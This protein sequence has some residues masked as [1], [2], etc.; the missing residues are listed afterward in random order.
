MT[1][2]ATGNGA[3][4]LAGLLA[5]AFVALASFGNFYVYDSIGPVADLL[6]R[7][8]GYSDTQI[9]TLNAIYSIPN[10][11][12]LLL[13]GILVD[14]IGAGRALF[15]TAL[16]CFLGAALTAASPSFY[17][18]AAGRLL[19]GIGAETFN[20]ATLA[21]VTLFYPRRHT[22]LMM[23]ITIGVGRAGSWVADLSPSL[24][25]GVYDAG[26]QWP[27]V[28]SAAIAATS[29]VASAAY[30]AVEH[31]AARD[32]KGGAQAQPFAWRDV[33]RFDISYWYLLIL[34]V[35]WYGVILAFRST[36]AIK[37]FQHAH[38]L[39]LAEAGQINSH[40]FLAALFATPAFGWLCDR[41]GRYAG[42][43]AAGAAL[44]PV[45]LALMA[46]GSHGLGLATA[47]IGISYSL[48]PAAMWPLVSRLVEPNRFGTALGL[49]WVIQNA[50]IAGANLAA[51]WLNDRAGAS[52]LHP[53]GYQPM[54]VFFIAASTLG[55]GFAVLL[56]LRSR[57]REA[58]PAT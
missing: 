41:I 26:W 49:M 31:R 32:V 48:V 7:Q 43:L 12:L 16:T 18:M 17:V 3:S 29:L 42:L 24:W 36:F 58:A 38:R 39:T 44:L 37:Y 34:C 2:S 15:W 19:F 21:A 14:R 52:A 11:V 5:M 57:G 25:K 8:L 46:A 53:S 4:A 27:L 33:L 40:V 51:G 20:I 6:Q 1:E 47:F 10:V 50:G 45:S 35:L 23:G 13:G 28:L 22:A 30:W 55:F 54:M 56:W 9:G